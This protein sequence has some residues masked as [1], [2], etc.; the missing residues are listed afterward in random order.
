MPNETPYFE[1]RKDD[2]GRDCMV[3]YIDGI[4]LLRF[5]LANKG[6]A[7][8]ALERIELG[9]DGLLPPAVNTLDQQVERAYSSLAGAPTPLARYQLLRA[10]QERHE[11]LFY[12]LLERHLE[13]LLPVV[14]TPTVGEAVQKFSAL[15]QHPRGLSF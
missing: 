2:A 3:A 12:A 10:L 11:V 5:P 9:L 1:I 14:Y 4:A 15:Y 7:F 13:E 6:T 8:T